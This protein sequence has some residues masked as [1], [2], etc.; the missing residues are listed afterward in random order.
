MHYFHSAAFY[1][2]SSIFLSR[3]FVRFVSSRLQGL[4]VTYYFRVYAYMDIECHIS[5]VKD[6][7]IVYI[8]KRLLL[9]G[10]LNNVRVQ[11]W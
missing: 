7:C 4:A 2:A 6:Y 9:D 8:F 3:A 11:S 5:G 10:S 1:D